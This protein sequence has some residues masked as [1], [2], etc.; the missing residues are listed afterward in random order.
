VDV[1][2]AIQK[3][4]FTIAIITLAIFFMCAPPDNHN[5]TCYKTSGISN[6]HFFGEEVMIRE[7]DPLSMKVGEFP[8]FRINGQL[9]AHPIIEIIEVNGSVLGYHTKGIENKYPDPI[10]F[11]YKIE[12]RVFRIMENGEVE[13]DTKHVNSS[14]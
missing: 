3:I 2:R 4:A 9:V 12:G 8:L 1:R 7:V 14:H 11:P 6:G 10:L 13:D 5:G